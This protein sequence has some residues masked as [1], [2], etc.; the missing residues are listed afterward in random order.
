ML[1]VQPS[2]RLVPFQ[3]LT[4]CHTIGHRP[5]FEST[6]EYP[7]MTWCASIS[8]WSCHEAK[9]RLTV[10][11]AFPRTWGCDILDS[12]SRTF[13]ES[14]PS[15]GPSPPHDIKLRIYG[16]TSPQPRT[17]CPKMKPTR[18]STSAAVPT[19]FVVCQTVCSTTGAFTSYTDLALKAFYS[20]NPPSFPYYITNVLTVPHADMTFYP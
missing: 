16:P 19:V 2:R 17:P 12:C 7:I 1:R 4:T 11:P 6:L 3:P 14:S 13:G 9:P 15:R 5:A 10:R 8:P 20:G 18:S